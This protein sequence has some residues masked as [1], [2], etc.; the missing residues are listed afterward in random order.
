M[1]KALTKAAMDA[2]DGSTPAPRPAYPLRKD[3]PVYKARVWR[4][5]PPAD[6]WERIR[7]LAS[8]PMNQTLIA[9]ELGTSDRVLRRWLK[10]DEDLGYAFR[11]GR[12]QLEN[13]LAEM[14]KK[15]GEEDEKSAVN[16]FVL[17]NR[18][19]GWRRENFEEQAAPNV[20]NNLTVIAPMS[21]DAYRKF[22]EQTVVAVVEAT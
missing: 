9:Y 16:L 14:I 13:E 15:K 18:F 5:D 8:K 22:L 12:A 20:T 1:A 7:D 3:P 6:V 21:V 2:Y 4:E 11:V 17:G 19:C 10:E